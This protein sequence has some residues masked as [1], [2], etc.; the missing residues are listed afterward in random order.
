MSTVHRIA[1]SAPV[2]SAAS[3]GPRGTPIG[4]IPIGMLVGGAGAF[5]YEPWEVYARQQ[6]TGVTDPNLIV[7]GR[8]G[9]GKSAMVNVSL[10][11]RG[12][13]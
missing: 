1:G 3:P 9:R 5:C 4:D 2:N 6:G 12:M 13:R 11:R 10:Y 8:L 7:W